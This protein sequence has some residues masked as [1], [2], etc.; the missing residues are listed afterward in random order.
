MT[1]LGTVLRFDERSASCRVFTRKEGALSVMAHDLELEVGRFVLE[2]D[3]ALAIRAS[4]DARSLRVLHAIVD[5][6][7]V[8]SLSEKDRATIDAALAK[9]VLATERYPTITFT[10]TARADRDGHAI[11]GTL[12]LHGVSRPLSAHSRAVGD[13]QVAEIILAQPEYGIRPFRAFLGALKV[14]PEVRVVV[15]VPWPS[16]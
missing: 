9:D 1:T 2:L 6:R 13:R 12:S 16:R 8:T 10:G 7:P 15:S 4:F 3:D 14:R 11:D 5:D